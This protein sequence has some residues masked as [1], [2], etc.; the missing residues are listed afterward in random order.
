MKQMFDDIKIEGEMPIGPVVMAACDSIYFKDHATALINSANKIGKDIHIHVV[1]P[2]QTLRAPQNLNINVTFSYHKAKQISRAY[3]ACIRF[4]IAKE[5]L[6]HSK[7]LLIV[8]VDSIFKNDFDWPKTNYGY[9]PREHK[10]RELQVAAGCVYFQEA[11]IETL[12]Q[13]ENKIASLP[14]EWYVDQK[15]LEWYFRNVIKD[16]I[17]YFDDKFMDWEFKDNT[18]L[19]TGKGKRKTRNVTYLNAKKECEKINI[20]S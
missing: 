10:Y 14:L 18:V 3:Y 5:I 16:S 19:W 15:A 20:S 13:L 6:K 11:A 8:D 17:T 7:K 4:I 2:T 9:F 12:P 1:N